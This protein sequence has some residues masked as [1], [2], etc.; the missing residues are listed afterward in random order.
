M[1]SGSGVT[2]PQPETSDMVKKWNERNHQDNAK[3]IIA[4]PMEFF[5]SLVREKVDFQVRKGEMY[6]GRLSE[7]FPDC[8]SSRMWIKQRT[9]KFET[10][11]LILERLDAIC[12]LEGCAILAQRLAPNLLEKN[13]FHC[14]ARCVTWYRN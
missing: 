9:K 4:T 5:K 1:P 11:L 7:V 13:S 6:S 10:S 3:M 8:T 12:H 14:Y 2:S